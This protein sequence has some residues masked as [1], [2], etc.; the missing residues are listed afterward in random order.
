MKP[1]T[2]KIHTKNNDYQ[3]IEVI[4]NN[5]KKRSKYGEF[6]VEGAKSINNIVANGWKIN[7]FIYAMEQPL[8]DW[9]KDILA[10]SKA[11]IHYELKHE[12][13]LDLS[14]KNEDYSEIL[15]LVEIP[16]DSYDRIPLKKDALIVLFDRPS[17]HGNLGTLLRSCEGL[18]VDGVILSGHGVDLYDVKTI[19]ASLGTMF[20]V[21]VVRAS[22]FQ[23]VHEWI[24]NVK[25]QLQDFQVVG[26]TSATDMMVDDAIF[27]HPTMLLVGNET[28]GLSHNFTEL[29]DVMVKIPM[30]GRITSFNVACAASMMLYEIDR[31]RRKGI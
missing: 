23:E 8:S 6:F 25:E 5:R 31:Q 20:S 13:M 21:P 15:A 29:C 9:A 16:Q 30:Y 4:K 18:G 22:S 14:D 26:S 19:R 2:V 27:T 12:L 28:L 1:Q 24:D 10:T 11:T 7:A 3:H 17:N